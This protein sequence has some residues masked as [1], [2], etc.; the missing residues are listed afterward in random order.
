[1]NYARQARSI[2]DEVT[3]N[4]FMQRKTVHAYAHEVA[5]K[6]RRVHDQ[7]RNIL[8]SIND[9]RQTALDAD[10][11]VLHVIH[12]GDNV[13]LYT[14]ATPKGRARKLIKRWQGPYVVV[15]TNDNGTSVI[16][17]PSGESLVS[18]DRL[19]KQEDVSETIEEQYQSDIELATQELK[20]IED[21]VQKMKARQTELQ[22]IKDIAETTTQAMTIDSKREQGVIDSLNSDA[23]EDIDDI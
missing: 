15:K 13:Y 17:K 21:S 23:N 12:E 2:T 7:V 11:A 9:E 4:D 14:E 8:T 20:A 1:M 6:L 18:N 16:L 19:R 10:D 5:D 22:L 3:D